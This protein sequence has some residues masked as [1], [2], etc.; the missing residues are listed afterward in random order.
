[1]TTPQNIN[2]NRRL[3]RSRDNRW[4]AGVLGGFADYFGWNA[5]V[6]RLLFFI[7]FILPG[8][9]LLLYLIAWIIMPNE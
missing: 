7:S 3:Q 4:V 5:N 1:M 8:S 9:Q 6:L 2:K